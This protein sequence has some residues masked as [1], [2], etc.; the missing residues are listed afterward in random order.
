M[1]LNDAVKRGLIARNPADHVDRPRAARK[2]MRWWSVAEARAFLDAA[3]DDRFV[4]LW[5]LALT[6]GMRR[7]ELLGLKWPDVDFDAGRLAVRRTLVAVQYRIRWSEPKT[8]SSR[9][10]VALDPATV[11]VLK[12]HRARQLEERM[13]I[14]SGYLDERIVFADVAGEPLHPDTVSKHFERVVARAG[15]PRI[16]LHDFRHTAATL[17]LERGVPLKAVTERLG[18]ASTQI[19]SDLYQHVGETMQD[20]A[21]AKLGAALLGKDGP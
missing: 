20:E 15:V 16:R 19:T 5:T 7:G 6:T 1:V 21:A 3:A 2:E 9:R 18:H 11:A 4:A 13:A 12:A 17:M 14:G 10:V 8:S